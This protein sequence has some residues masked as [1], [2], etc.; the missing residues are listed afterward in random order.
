MANCH[1]HSDALN[2]FYEDSY[3]VLVFRIE[4]VSL[5]I[6]YFELQ[7]VEYFIKKEVVLK[8]L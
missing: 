3:I 8:E 5:D 6:S 1:L 4:E 7:N 2:I